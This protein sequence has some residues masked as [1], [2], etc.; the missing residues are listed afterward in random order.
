MG[1]QE[2]VDRFF[3]AFAS[4]LPLQTLYLVRPST[5]RTS[6]V[7]RAADAVGMDQVGNHDASFGRF[8][9]A[10]EVQRY[11]V[12][13]GPANRVEVVDSHVFVSLNTMALDSDVTHK[14]VQTQARRR[15]PST[16]DPTYRTGTNTTMRT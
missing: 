11:E 4:A 5:R 3:S 12:A 9:S 14:D 15:G 16:A 6:G 8:M 10:A 1:W 13:F 2:Y 7:E